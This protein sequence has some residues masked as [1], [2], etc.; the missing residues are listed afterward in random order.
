MIDLL[1]YTYDGDLFTLDGKA[2]QMEHNAQLVLCF[3]TCTD[4]ETLSITQE[5]DTLAGGWH[6]HEGKRYCPDCWPDNAPN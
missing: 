3:N 6:K 4:C 1:L 2:I 5:R